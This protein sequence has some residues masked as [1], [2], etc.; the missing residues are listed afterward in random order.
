M[1][2][3]AQ[4]F[5]IKGTLKDSLKEPVAFATIIA[6]SDRDEN[7]VLG[8]TTSADNGVFL[9]KLKQASPQDSIWITIR[10]LEHARKQLHFKAVSQNITVILEKQENQL[11]EVQLKAKRTIE[12]KG[13]T[14]TYNVEGLKKEKDYTIEEVIARIPGVEISDS[15]QIKYKDKAISYLYLNG[16]DL[17]EGRYNI[18]T[19]GIPADAVEDIDIMKK[20]NHARIDKGR[21]ESD[22]VAFNL[23][24]KKDRSLVFG[25]TKADA[26]VPFLTGLAEGTPIYIEDNFQDIASVK[27]NNI[28]KSLASNGT[29]LT[30]GNADLS[31]LELPDVDILT[32]PNTNGTSIS[33]SYWLDNESFSIT[34]DALIKSSDQAI[35][36]A[37][38]TYNKGDNQ[39]DRFSNATY[40]FDNDS[41]QVNR[42][43]RN[44]LQEELFYL[45]LV[46]E[47]NKDRLY[48]N[49]K[50]KLSTERT[51]G[52]SSNIQN[53][54]TI[55]YSYDRSTTRLSD[56]LEF[57]TTIGEQ[58]L[59]NGF[60]IEF[61]ESKET[62]FTTPAVFT[63]QIPSVI[64]P[65]VT[66]QNIETKRFNIGGYSGFTFLIGKTKWEAKQ[67]LRW[68]SENLQ[69]DLFQQST[70]NNRSQSSF[71]FASDFELN[72]LES[73]TSLKSSYQIGRFKL[74]VTPQI[75]Y[76]YLDKE[77]LLQ[78]D[79]NQKEDY[80]FFEPSASLSYKLSYK[81]NFSL[82]G[83][84]NL[85]TSR[86]SQ[87]YNG[88]AL[89]DFT[90]LGRNPDAINV[91]RA[92]SA[93]FFINYD[94]ILSGFFFNNATRFNDNTSD[95]TFSSN[96]DKNGLIQTIAI[97]RENNST[98][99]SNSS[100]FT[101][102]FF[103]ILRTD[104]RYSF[105]YFE[106]EQF[107]NG[108]AQEFKNT[109]H[110]INLELGLD[111]N[112]WYGITYNGG[113]NYGISKV[114]NL[115]NTN[116]FLKHKL[117]LDFYTSSKSR[118]NVGLE[119]VSSTTS[120]NDVTNNN[121]LT[122]ISYYYKP[123]K[124]LFLRASMNNIFNE[125]F[126]TTV[127]NSSNFI[128]Q[129]QFSLRPRQFT[130]GLNYSL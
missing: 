58:V 111:N 100:N 116:L 114:T 23:K 42:Q 85:S 4:Q 61:S 77:E 46:Q 10:H 123:N 126:F 32:E 104:L 99:F 44:K 63:D 65:D 117:E 69:S 101:K 6:S 73:S 71:P 121:T 120:T 60:L 45:G 12:V 68:S 67:R 41:T 106:G 30:Q 129:S 110:S 38:T 51:D 8:Y 127:Q 48:L 125:D 98:S 96:I 54:E 113:F 34:N 94:D 33:D 56:L 87:L 3:N 70:N 97:E 25:S 119:S 75:S 14:I 20:H 102:R 35:F 59:N 112:T 9:L 92:T 47:I 89:R 88:I 31:T 76:L 109:N 37:G 29:N 7:N 24:I 84:R 49:N 83:S 53:G 130:I 15:G 1:A 27:I 52:L 50:I 103:R 82:S 86:F 2:S 107:F 40:F 62:S 118:L 91:T 13:D 18:A 78:T 36:K 16:V 57:K 115:R 28:G 39:I 66:T 19:R 11:K 22:D 105:S 93:M 43:T 128:S 21:T 5:E 26:G 79:L 72:Q 55:D 64:N 80:L 74:R 95:F 124:K 122:N 17:L 108:N 81:W 90:S